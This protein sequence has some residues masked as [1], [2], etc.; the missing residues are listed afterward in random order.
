MWFSDKCRL[1]Q[2]LSFII[3]I[4]KCIVL[5]RRKVYKPRWRTC[6]LISDPRVFFLI[7]NITFL[8]LKPMHSGFIKSPIAERHICFTQTKSCDIEV[9]MLNWPVKTLKCFLFKINRCNRPDFIK[10][11]NCLYYVS[12]NHNQ[13]ATTKCGIFLSDNSNHNDIVTFIW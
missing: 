9:R 13:I 8:I 1:W 12:V 7:K 5:K 11:L 3:L 10:D 2:L 4:Q 6:V